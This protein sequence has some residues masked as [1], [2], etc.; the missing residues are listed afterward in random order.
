MRIIIIITVV[1]ENLEVPSFGRFETARQI[2][3]SKRKIL[4]LKDLHISF[5]FLR[6][7]KFWS[8]ISA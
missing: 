6:E 1:G 7:H 5:K 3:R 2:R 8:N 4:R